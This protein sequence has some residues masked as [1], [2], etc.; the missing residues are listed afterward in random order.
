[1]PWYKYEAEVMLDNPPLPGDADGWR[2]LDEE[3]RTN[4]LGGWTPSMITNTSF[5]PKETD[6]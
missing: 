5:T 4:I 2:A 6:D 3:F 1:M